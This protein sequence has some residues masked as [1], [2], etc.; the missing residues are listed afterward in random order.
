MGSPKKGPPKSTTKSQGKSKK[1]HAWWSNAPKEKKRGKKRPKVKRKNREIKFYKDRKNP[2]QK[3][4]GRK[5]AFEA[6]E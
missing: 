2:D 1:T 5:Q 4:E 3:H 6:S